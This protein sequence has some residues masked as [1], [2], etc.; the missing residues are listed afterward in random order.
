MTDIQNPTNLERM[1]DMP[2][3]KYVF[4]LIV[5]FSVSNP[6]HVLKDMTGWNWCY[7]ERGTVNICATVTG[8]NTEIQPSPFGC[9]LRKAG[10]RRISM[11]AKSIHCFKSME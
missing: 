9:M 1:E 11:E 8:R 2:E 3:K 4:L 6:T 7:Y 10:E 5:D